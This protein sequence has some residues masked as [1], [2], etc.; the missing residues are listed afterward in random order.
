VQPLAEVVDAPTADTPY[1]LREGKLLRIVD[2]NSESLL[3]LPG[4]SYCETDSRGQ[5]IWL[6]SPAGISVYDPASRG[7]ELI[8]A[9]K[10]EP[11]A[12]FEVR[13]GLD[14]GKVGNADP[15]RHDVAL[16]VVAAKRISM[17]SEIICEGERE[18]LCYVETHSD[19][20]DMWE[21][22]EEASLLKSLYD[23]LKLSQTELLTQI[24]ARRRAAADPEEATEGKTT[25]IMQIEGA[26]PCGTMRPLP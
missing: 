19:D 21:L 6:L 13:F 16:I 11:I 15:L 5:A 23:E 26:L 24:A 3:D 8:V 9:A 4:A 18:E 1:F 25:P 14:E 2:G 17:H 7:S 10:H 20:P 22:Q 12:A